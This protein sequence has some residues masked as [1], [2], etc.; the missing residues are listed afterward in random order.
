MVSTSDVQKVLM[1][2][3]V[4]TASNLNGVNSCQVRV[5]FDTGS[6][7]SYINQNVSDSLRLQHQDVEKIAVASFGS[8]KR[9][10][11]EFPVV[12]A[13]IALKYGT[14]KVIRLNVTNKITCPLQKV[15]LGKHT[16]LGKLQLAEPLCTEPEEMVIDILI[17]ADQYYEL[18][19]T[20]RLE[21]Q[22][23]LILVDSA[24]GFLLAGTING[25]ENKL[26]TLTCTDAVTLTA[27]DTPGD[28]NLERFWNLETIGISEETPQTEDD[29]ALEKFQNSVRFVNGR[30]FV[31][32]PWKDE[33]CD[34][35]ENFQLAKAACNH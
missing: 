21:Y 28:L 24:L 34:L 15:P 4:T 11:G 1:Q 2:T 23:G 29:I 3:A 7:R 26:H 19:G 14:S 13:S 8:T 10:V 33:Q 32:W 16:S 5:L 27:S 30:Y 35:P 25:W 17:G 12:E 20:E 9:V 22:D 18:V 6:S 31:S